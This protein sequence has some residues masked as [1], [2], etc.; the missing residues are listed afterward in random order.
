M[1]SRAPLLVAIIA[2][3]AFAGCRRTVQLSGGMAPTINPGERVTI[4]YVAYQ[5]TRLRRWDVVAFSPPMLPSNSLVLKRVI[6]LPLET[7]SLTTNGIVI[8]GRFLAMPAALSNVASFPS[9]TLLQPCAMKFPYTVPANNYFVIGD[10][11]TNSLDSRYYGAV[12]V[13]NI[14]GRVMNK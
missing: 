7:I 3:V 9:G 13:A 8:N 2:L 14:F 6:A 12:P 11:W 5:D 1:K 4:D 10:N